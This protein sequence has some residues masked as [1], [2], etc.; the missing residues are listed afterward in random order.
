ME[1]SIFEKGYCPTSDPPVLRPFRFS[2]A[3]GKKL[4]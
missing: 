2:L 3:F 4:W 1:T